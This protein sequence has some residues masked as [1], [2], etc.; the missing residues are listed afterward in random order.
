MTNGV[1]DS[2]VRADA[3]SIILKMVRR[4]PRPLTVS[5]IHKGLPMPYRLELRELIKVLNDQAG[6]EKFFKWLPYRNQQRYWA[7]APELYAGDRIVEILTERALTRN[8]LKATLKK[9]LFGCSDNK[10]DDLVRKKLKQLKG[11]EKIYE[12]PPVG[13]LRSARFGVGPPDPAPYLKKAIKEYASACRILQKAGLS[14]E[15]VFLAMRQIL[16]PSQELPDAGNTLPSHPE[17][18]E[19]ILKKIMEVQPAAKQ[20]ALVLIPELRAAMNLP[21][22]IFDQAILELA[23]QDTLIL[24]RHVHTARMND[25]ERGEMVTD[26]QGNYYVGVVLRSKT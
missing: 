2:P 7:Y 18:F 12:H 13:R 22:E 5:N 19:N 16:A 25:K 15:Q 14:S 6:E 11:E 4:S 10:L 20:E 1:T 24:H 17:I 8:E 26:G 9:H 3:I 23:V 21:K